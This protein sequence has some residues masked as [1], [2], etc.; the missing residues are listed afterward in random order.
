MS[1][2]HDAIEYLILEGAA[3][4][5]GMDLETGDMLYRFTPA[6]ED[7]FP[8]TYREV[9]NFFHQSLLKLWELGFLEMDIMSSDPSVRP[10]DFAYDPKAIATLDA[11]E[12]HTLEAVL[13]QIPDQ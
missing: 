11:V 9:T 4:V 6:L 12:R 10:T 8:E 7:K 2:D 13:Q 1:L 5:A 3:E